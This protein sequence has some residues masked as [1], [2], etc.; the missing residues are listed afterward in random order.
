M[1]LKM[2][3]YQKLD[4]N[5]QVNLRNKE[6]DKFNSEGRSHIV[7]LKNKFSLTVSSLLLLISLF[8]GA[9]S[10]PSDEHDLILKRLYP[11]DILT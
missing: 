8:S 1:I 5:T 10:A 9:C 3:P 4:R 2:V 7:L 11:S 6:H